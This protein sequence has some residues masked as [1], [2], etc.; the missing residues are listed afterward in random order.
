LLDLQTSFSIGGF[1]I[2]YSS[3]FYSL[4]TEV[5]GINKAFFMYQ[6]CSTILINSFF[7]FDEPI[8]LPPN[9][10]PVGML[11]KSFGTKL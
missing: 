8:P 4:L 7:G 10:R 2:S 3:F 1:T 9:I 5:L 6:D 11:E